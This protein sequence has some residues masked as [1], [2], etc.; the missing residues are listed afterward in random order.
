MPMRFKMPDDLREFVAHHRT[1]HHMRQ[2]CFAQ[3]DEVAETDM[4]QVGQ[5]LFSQPLGSRGICM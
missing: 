2:A 4:E 3:V 1:E 5:F